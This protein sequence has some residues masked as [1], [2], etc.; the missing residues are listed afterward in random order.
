MVRGDGVC[1]PM[2]GNSTRSDI[3]DRIEALN[4]TAAC[5]RCVIVGRKRPRSWRRQTDIRRASADQTQI[6]GDWGKS[7]AAVPTATCPMVISQTA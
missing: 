5:N 7:S 1:H 2:T 4:V 3:L 6:N